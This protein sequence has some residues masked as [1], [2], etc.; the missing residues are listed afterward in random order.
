MLGRSKVFFLFSLGVL[1]FPSL[2]LAQ[3]LKLEDVWREIAKDSKVQNAAQLDV[4]AASAASERAKI[5][6]LPRAYLD[7]KSFE[8]NDP[9][10]SFFGKLSERAVTTNDF[11]PTALNHPASSLYTRGALGIDLALYEG[12]MK[13]S[14]REM[15]DH[16]LAGKKEEQHQVLTNEFVEVAQAYGAINSLADQRENLNDI[17]TGLLRLIKSY[18]LGNRSNPVGY[19]GLLGLK[20][21]SNRIQALINENRSKGA[22]H[23][24]ELSQLGL[25]QGDWR[26]TK[27]KAVEYVARYFKSG[28]AAESSGSAARKEMALAAESGAAMEKSRYLPKVGAFAEQ[29]VFNGSRATDSGYSAGLYLQWNLFNPA[30]YGVAKE[31][32]LKA[33]AAEKYAAYNSD[34][35]RSAFLGIKQAIEATRQNLLL[36]TE[37]Q[38]L[39][40]EQTQTAEELFRN[41]SINAL[42]LV[43]ALSRRA[44]LIASF[45]DAELNLLKLHGELAMKSK[46]EIPIGIEGTAQ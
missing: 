31:A 10:L 14:Q 33:A 35:E 11:D 21:L 42:Q 23:R 36:M 9:G 25:K 13:S 41:G 7:V 28:E 2:V 34:Q 39:L 5:N 37:S 1:S 24:E 29:Y 15:Q 45:T 6:W 46:F 40:V 4:E 18:K 16:L 17:Q 3:E 44:D 43:E 20:A 26:P 32:H 27:S 19:S 12:G 8:T 30:D 38:K 22:A